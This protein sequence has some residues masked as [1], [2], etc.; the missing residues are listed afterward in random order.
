MYESHIWPLARDSHNLF[1]VR[2]DFYIIL[3]A[4]MLWGHY[5]SFLTHVIIICYFI[6]LLQG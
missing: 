3:C 2:K 5:M 6:G 4:H 1:D